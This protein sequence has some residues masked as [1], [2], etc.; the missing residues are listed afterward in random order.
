MRGRVVLITGGSSGVG[1]AAAADLARL[2][3]RVV[4]LS[5]DPHRAEQA[6]RQLAAASG[7]E[8]IECLQADLAEG[9][10]VAGA[11]REFVERYDRLDVLMNCAGVLYPKRRVSAEGVE[12]T[13][14]V[15]FLGHFRLTNLLLDA[16]KRS[17]P[18]RVLTA[19][20]NAWPLR[21]ARIHFDDLQLQRGYNPLKAKLQAELAKTLF[22]MELARRLKGTGVSSNAFHPGLIR[23]GIVRHLPWY[24]RI[25]ASVGMAV[26]GRRTRTGVHLAAAER[27]EGVSGRFF[28]RVGVERT[29][30]LDEETARRLWEVAASLAGL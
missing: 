17:A 6:R 15:E 26:L 25:P 23:S 18:A 11:A 29:A 27:L 2:G 3:A 8:E 9:R 16:L 14:A 20:G 28:E 4:L 10:S 21:F 19:T 5:R 13:L 12:M 30:P 24:L 1:R 22:A 7:N